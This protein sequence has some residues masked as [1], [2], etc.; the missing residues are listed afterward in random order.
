M[1]NPCKIVLLTIALSAGSLPA[2]ALDS[3]RHQP[4]SIEADQGSL[5]QKNQVTVFSG[6]VVVKQGSI[7][8]KA[9]TVRVAQTGKGQQTMLASGNP[10]YF[11]QQLEG[12]K[13]IA[14]GWGNRAEYDSAQNLVKLLG[15]AK[16]Q[17]GGDLAQGEAISY[18][19]HTE[20]YTVLGGNAT[21][22]KNGRRVTV[23]I[24]P[25]K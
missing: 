5:D 14:E 13:G 19:M 4:I 7:L 22:N 20:I 18:N 21:G 17:R 8:M 3:D 10:V 25:T 24:Q 11:R 23:I 6:N 12:D 2:Y 15:N 1:R 16:V 9:Q